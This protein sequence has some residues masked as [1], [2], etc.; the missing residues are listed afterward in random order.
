MPRTGEAVAQKA[1]QLILRVSLAQRRRTLSVIMPDKP[2]GLLDHLVGGGQQGFWDGEA[3]G[4]GGLEI[5]DQFELDGLLH[6]QLGGLLALVWGLRSQAPIS[7]ILSSDKILCPRKSP[8]RWPGLLLE[9][10]SFLVRRMPSKSDQSHLCF[11][12]KPNKSE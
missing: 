9:S 10:K 2:R 7:R 4:F 6:R 11:Q 1:I 8:K 5:E 3:E 12:R